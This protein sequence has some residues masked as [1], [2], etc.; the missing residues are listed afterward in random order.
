M[1]G[2]MDEWMSRWVDGEGR[3]DEEGGEDG[4]TMKQPGFLPH[5]KDNL[6]LCPLP[7]ALCLLPSAPCPLPSAFYL[8]P[9]AL[10]P[11]PSAFSP[12]LT[13]LPFST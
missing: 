8:L 2:W 3:E 7:F 12:T 1:G 10:C 13:P 11:L 6:T 9:S 5:Q 4:E